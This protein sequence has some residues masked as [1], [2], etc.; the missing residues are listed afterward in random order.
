MNDRVRDFFPKVAGQLFVGME[1][2]VAAGLAATQLA[3][4]TNMPT[5]REFGI[6]HD[7]GKAGNVERQL[8]DGRWIR[9]TGSAGADGAC[10][11]FLTDLTAIKER[12][13]NFLAAK[14]AAE[15]ANA[16]KSRF[17]A[18][19]SHELR[20]PLNAIIGFSEMISGEIFGPVGN[21]R[22]SEYATDI[23][24]SGRHLL[25]IINSVLDLS[26]SEAGKLTLQKEAVD[27]RFV[28]RDCTRM[29][30]DFCKTG[31][32]VLSN[33]EPPGPVLVGG[34]KAKLRQIFLN[35]LSNAVK[36]TEPGGRVMIALRQSDDDVTVE[37]VDTGIG[38]SK[39][40]IDVALTP[41]GQVDTRLARRYEGTGL[42]LPLTKTL[43]DLHGGTLEIESEPR[44][45]TVVRVHLPR[46]RANE[47]ELTS[48]LAS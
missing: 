2:S 24:R 15:A 10:I 38:M 17:L 48:A 21:A 13:E 35:L 41:F 18:N 39:D 47:Q 33:A 34:E 40:D 30:E 11:F 5:L 46:A 3:D 45:G 9:I 29:L 23:L 22:Y 36:F 43:V 32:L 1:Y 12:E 37:I 20:T 19:M 31:G 26:R 4:G 44:V 28:L 42:G 6:G 27:L 25:D 16:A 8:A 14:H 7:L